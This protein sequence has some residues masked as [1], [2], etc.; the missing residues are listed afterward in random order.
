MGAQI[1]DGKSIAAEIRSDLKVRID[2]LKE[3]GITPGLT[4]VLVGDDPASQ[5][6][7][8]SKQ[9]TSGEI[10]INSNVIELPEDTAQSEL[11]DLIEQLNQD[12][13][14]H[15]ILVQLP[16]PRHFDTDAV[17]QAVS[18]SKDVDG[19]HPINVGNLWAGLADSFAPCTP[20]GI[21]ELLRRTGVDPAGMNAVVIGRS[22]I[23]G[24]P[25]AGLLLKA[26]ATVTI[27]HSRTK[28]LEAHVKNADILIVAIGQ[29]RFVKD[30]WIKP[31]AVIIDVGM[32]RVDGKLCGDVDESVKKVASHIT[33][34]P[35][36]VG[37]MTI[38]QLLVNT[39]IAAE[40]TNFVD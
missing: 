2:R 14:V 19:F 40:R 24:K 17:I 39:V 37:P 4:V 20:V 36:G 30:S 12:D 22:N 8:R 38:A 6:Y 33:P 11:I 15:G 9:R 16:L 18:P 1:I 7:V 29:P 35:G 21:M 26:N 28:D 25:M 3:K 27:C 5:T 31:G 13:T 34:V 23:V 32:N 10:G